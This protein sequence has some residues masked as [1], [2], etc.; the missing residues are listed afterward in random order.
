MIAQRF[1]GI[2]EV[3]SR[4]RIGFFVALAIF[5]LWSYFHWELTPGS[6]EKYPLGFFGW[7]DQGHY[8]DSVGALAHLDFDPRKHI[9]PIGYPLMGAFFA[10]ISPWHPFL[11]PNLVSLGALFWGLGSLLRK[12]FDTAVA[13]LVAVLLLATSAEI[14]QCGLMAPWTTIPVAAAFVCLLAC[15]LF[16]SVDSKTWVWAGILSSI[17]VSC[18]PVGLMAALPALVIPCIATYELNIRAYVRAVLLFVAGFLP[19][20]FL[21]LALQYSIHGPQLMSPVYLGAVSRFGFSSHGFFEKAFGLFVDA[22]PVYGLSDSMLLSVFPLM[23]FLGAR[24]SARA[25][26][27]RSLLDISAP[28]ER[29]LESGNLPLLQRF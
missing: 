15:T 28:L 4:G 19:W 1:S 9:Y 26:A 6:L 23:F 18:R 2:C 3:G 29:G 24:W 14:F 5:Y 13:D 7:A 16:R 12:L 10:R 27:Q 8:L 25:V 17:I 21:C 20:G 22:S 11:I